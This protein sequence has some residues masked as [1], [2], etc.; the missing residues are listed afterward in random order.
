LWTI[1]ELTSEKLV[2]SEKLFGDKEAT[3]E[4]ARPGDS[5]KLV[6]RPSKRIPDPNFVPPPTPPAAQPKVV[7]AGNVT[8]PLNFVPAGWVTAADG[9]TLILSNS[10]RAEL[11]FV[12]TEA[13]KESKRVTLEFKP[14]A[15]TVQNK[16]LI[17]VA[18]GSA[19]V[20]VLDTETGKE[21]G[22]IQAGSDPIVSLACHPTKGKVYAASARYDI[23]GID[24]ASNRAV[25]TSAKGLFLAVDPVKAD[26]VYAGIQGQ[27]RDTVVGQVN[28]NG[29]VRVQRAS[30]GEHARLYKYSIEGDRLKQVGQNENAATNGYMMSVSAD[31]RQIAVVGGGGYR[32]KDGKTGGYVIAVFDTKDVSTVLGQ[33]EFSGMGHP[34]NVAFHPLLNLGVAE[35]GSE[36]LVAFNG[37][38]LAEVQALP[39]TNAIGGL[40]NVLTFGAGG[41]KVVY[42][43]DDHTA[44]G[45]RFF[46]L[47]LNDDQKKALSSR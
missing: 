22:E 7:T 42:F 40:P 34:R 13:E 47:T 20:H 44:K 43:S 45:L 37:K 10:D 39:V 41:R 11:V 8:I 24:I 3:G 32:P 4:F 17:A 12:D 15:L 26:C 28:P 1:K 6:N 46:E 33:I 19:I 18:K 14:A 16:K 36:N 9:K 23:I 21:L 5:E 27:I 2:V 25:P 31:G 30:S 29:S 35:N 38:S